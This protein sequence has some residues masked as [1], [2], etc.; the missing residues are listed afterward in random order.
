M[1]IKFRVVDSSAYNTKYTNQFNLVVTSP[2]YP[3]IEMWGEEF[4]FNKGHALLKRVYQNCYS[5]LKAGSIMVV[6]IADATRRI[7][8]EFRV[9]SN[10]AKTITMMEE[11]GFISLPG[12][13]WHK[14]ANA[15]NKFLGSGMLPVNAYVTQEIERILIFRKGKEKRSFSNIE[16]E[17]RRKSKFTIEERNKWFSCIWKV[18]GERQSK[19]EL[20]RRTA[21]FPYEIAYRLIRMFSIEGDWVLDPFC[22]TG[23]TGLACKNTNRNSIGLDISKDFIEYA[24]KRMKNVL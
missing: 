10:V 23:T 15:P 21:A 3:M 1:E 7:D 22:G 13:Y 24:E 12:I 16:K 8:N 20:A 2:P 9:Y 14:V 18:A 11:L 19:N 6:N 17:L 5:Y 4:E